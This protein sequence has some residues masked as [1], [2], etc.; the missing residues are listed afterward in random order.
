MV[1][2]IRVAWVTLAGLLLW[3]WPAAG[4][5]QFGDVSSNLNGTISGG[6]T[7]DYGNLVNSAHSWT[8]GGT[9]QFTGAYYN[10]N[11]LSFNISP[12]LNQSRANANYQ[13]ISD[14]SGVN[15]SS[16]IFAG[17]HF[18]GS[19]SY[20]KAYNSEGNYAVPGVANFTTHGNSDAF[21]INWSE[22]LPD[23][24]SLS[25]GFQSGS[26]QYS[27]YGSNDSG[28]S[29]FHSFNLHSAYNLHGFTLGGAFSAGTGSSLVPE[30]ANGEQAMETHSD[31]KDYSFNV[32]HSLPLRGSFSAGANRADVNSDYL[33]NSY[34]GTIDT[35][36]SVA[37][38]QPTNKLHISGTA[39]YS[40]N[41]T[42]QLFQQVLATGGV[43]PS[44]TSSQSSHSSDFLGTVS[45]AFL[46][47]LQ[48]S[49]F[50]ERRSQYFL[51]GTYG[52]NSYGG[53]AIYGHAILGGSFNG[54]VTISD[55]T[56]DN[57]NLNALGLST[58]VNYSRRILGWNV[59]GSFAYA[60]N[61]QTLLVTYTSSF[62][63]YS[64]NVRRRWGLLNFSAGASAART[65]LTEQPGT[66]NSSEGYNASVGYGRW[67]T[68]TGSYSRSNG[69]ALQTSTGLVTVP[70]TP[71]VVPSSLMII[72]G[73]KSYSAGF[74]SAPM[75]RMT[76]SAT[77]SKVNSNTTFDSAASTN[78]SDQ[79]NAFM[80]YQVRKMYV[81]GG[82]SRLEQ[83]FSI[84]GAP[85]EVIS[86]FYIGV[87]RWFNFF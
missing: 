56:L 34:N 17:S 66:S 7:G 2:P 22:N 9:G 20:A 32:G 84:S 28:N 13:S 77:Y 50:A 16:N 67:A 79:F 53:S 6:Y 35:F 36:N 51:G 48:T 80:Q 33:G 11:F 82:F 40:D 23:E 37:T 49:A 87:S 72:Y 78:Q 46:P 68:L 1:S 63:N 58:T 24:P 64:G 44:S 65:G 45:Y 18:P 31:S 81:T 25:L 14:A 83:G 26:S 15:I 38:L 10:P 86:S 43:I 39:T 4:Q 8:V 47:N 85:P 55:N 30:I 57:T 12:Y 73:G 52:S 74:A 76:I 5:M 19:I 59:A 69:N 27:V 42:G 29:K 75:K 3:A 61:V 54:A 70:V 21:G 41:L 60:Q 62:Y 71:P